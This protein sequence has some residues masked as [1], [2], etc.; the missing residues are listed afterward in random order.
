[1][2]KKVSS[3]VVCGK[4]TFFWNRTKESRRLRSRQ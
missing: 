4:V 2:K 3:K 1:M